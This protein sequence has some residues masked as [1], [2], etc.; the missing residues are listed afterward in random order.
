M[1]IKVTLLNIDN[2]PA[3]INIAHIQG[4]RP[5]IDY[6]SIWLSNGEIIRVKD[7]ESQILKL[8]KEARDHG[9]QA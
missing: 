1:F 8:I 9:N 5:H 2:S 4:F 6:T 3:H 7:T